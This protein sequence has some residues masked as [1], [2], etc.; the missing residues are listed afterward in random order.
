MARSRSWLTLPA[1][2]TLLGCTEPPATPNAV[3]SNGTSGVVPSIPGTPSTLTCDAPARQGSVE[4]NQA[5]DALAAGKGQEATLGFLKAIQARPN[6]HTA[7]ALLIAARKRQDKLSRDVEAGLRSSS[8]I[9]LALP[10][11]AAFVANAVTPRDGAAKVRLTRKSSSKNLIIDDDDWF[12]KNGL[13]HALNG[14]VL[15]DHVPDYMPR[16]FEGFPIDGLFD[17]GDHV[18]GRYGTALVAGAPGMKPVGFAA[19]APPAPQG[20][21]GFAKMAGNAI[22][23]S[24][25]QRSTSRLAAFDAKS[26]ALQWASEGEMAS[27]QTFEMTR[28][29]ILSGDGGSGSPDAIFLIDAATGKTLQ[30][31]KLGTAPTFLVVKGNELFIRSYDTDYVFGFSA[32]PEKSEPPV[33]T[34][35]AAPAR[36]IPEATRCAFEHALAASDARDLTALASAVSELQ[37]GKADASVIG[38]FQG[39]GRFL[40]QQ[41][42]TAALDLT[43]AV[44]TV[45]PAPPW[46]YQL[47]DSSRTASASKPKLTK[48]SSTAGGSPWVLRRGT[49]D[50]AKP[51][52]IP[53]VEKGKLPAGA[54]QDIPSQYGNEDLGLIIPDG[55][56]LILVYG[57]RYVAVTKGSKT[58]AVL[59]LEAYRHPPKVN[60]Q[61]KDFAVGD[62]TYAL[63][64]GDTIYIANGGGS[65]A[66]EMFGKKGFMSAISLSTGKLLWRSQPLVTGSGPFARYDDFLMTGYGFTA[67]PDN[68]FLLDKATGKVATK[69]S[70]DSAPDGIIL[71]GSRA[72][73]F[74][75]DSKL[76]FEI[77]L[78]K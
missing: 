71:S 11:K 51:W 2:L 5:I 19:A 60:P 43:T 59:D 3:G 47:L 21:I 48:K 50:P 52:I 54:R 28:D 25:A 16:V 62:V 45:L 18:I 23:L 36:A 37:S 69:M 77:T 58:E 12:E 40:E 17:H 1:L 15:P 68:V 75:Y 4:R 64:D 32:P 34:P 42:R 44:P 31:E 73:V 29:H 78:S 66:K 70:V 49:Y 57:G 8:P 41:A 20:N 7:Q 76:E 33:F 46:D 27:S 35:V 10:L 22:V 55:E 26:G 30:K 38:A 63:T 65:Y 39:V 74:T 53:P 24:L 6:D 56:R 13:P 9:V 72:T 14:R 61:W 67:E